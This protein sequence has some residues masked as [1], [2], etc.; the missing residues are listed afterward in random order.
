MEKLVGT[1]LG[2]YEIVE[3]IGHGAVSDVYKAYQPK[4]NRHVAL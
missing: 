3:H 4:L 1:K 2:E